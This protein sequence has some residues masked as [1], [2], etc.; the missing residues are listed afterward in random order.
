MG[1]IKLPANSVKYFN[2]HYNEIFESGELAEGKWN[3]RVVDWACSYT[4]AS[5]AIGV[6][7]RFLPGPDCGITLHVRL[8]CKD[9]NF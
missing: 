2:D 1:M 7:S 4:S 6:N 5:H 9:K 3:R 8:P